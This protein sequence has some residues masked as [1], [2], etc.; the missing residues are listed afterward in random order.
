[1]TINTKL[2]LLLYGS[3]L[4]I[5][6]QGMNNEE[7]I[8]QIKQDLQQDLI[9]AIQRY[10]TKTAIHLVALRANINQIDEKTGKTPLDYAANNM[11]MKT[12][13][14]KTAQGDFVK[15]PPWQQYLPKPPRSN[16]PFKP[17]DC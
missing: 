5:S 1:M 3:L 16:Q 10:E 15:T 2:I 14:E 6:V 4:S 9:Q 13:L 7:K 11:V 17:V 12:V 8:A